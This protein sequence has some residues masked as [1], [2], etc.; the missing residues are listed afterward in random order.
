MSTT[1]ETGDFIRIMRIAYTKQKEGSANS[2][3]PPTPPIHMD[4]QSFVL[5]K[6]YSDGK[7]TVADFMAGEEWTAKHNWLLMN[8]ETVYVMSPNG[9]K[10]SLESNCNKSFQV[11]SSSNLSINRNLFFAVRVYFN[12]GDSPINHLESISDKRSKSCCVM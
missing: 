2:S 5:H 10:S 1:R 11:I 12:A 6:S 7:R 8:C 9:M 3:P 4:S